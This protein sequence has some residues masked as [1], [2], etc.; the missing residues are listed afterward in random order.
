MKSKL[1]AMILISSLWMGCTNEKKETSPKE[2]TIDFKNLSEE[3]ARELAEK[4]S[5]LSSFIS[6][7]NEIQDNLD[8]IK[9]REKIITINSSNAEFQQKRSEQ[10]ISDMRAIADMMEKNKQRVESL[11]KKLKA[12]DVKVDGLESMIERLTREIQ[13]KDSI[14]ADLQV[15]LIEANESFRSLLSTYDKT[16]ENLMD[17]ETKLNTAFYAIG[18]TKELIKN[19]VLTKEGGF[20]GL[21]K[22]QKLSNDFNRSYF[23]KVDIRETNSIQLMV[24]KAKLMT[25]HPA[26][27]YKF[28]NNDKKIEALEILNAEDFWSSSKYLVIVVE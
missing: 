1:M 8:S 19:G 17:S 15:K 14:I 13:E 16:S 12:S 3:Q 9:V 10:I 21:G 5:M 26:A 2:E 28:R 11:R 23:T 24:K 27:S 6:S 4:D 22:T 7:F 18:S 25:N 20:I